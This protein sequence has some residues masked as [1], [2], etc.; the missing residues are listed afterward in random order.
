MPSPWR[1]AVK[2][3]GDSNGGTVWEAPY[4][5]VYPEGLRWDCRKEYAVCFVKSIAKERNNPV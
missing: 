5:T 2:K 1:V 4:F 3:Q